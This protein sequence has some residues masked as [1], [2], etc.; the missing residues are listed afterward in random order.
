MVNKKKTNKKA[1]KKFELLIE[2]YTVDLYSENTDSFIRN[3][4]NATLESQKVCCICFRMFLYQIKITKANLGN[5]Q[6]GYVIP[7]FHHRTPT[8]K[9]KTIAFTIAFESK[10]IRPMMSRIWSKKICYAMRF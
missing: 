5:I 2:R 3:I 8:Y 10:N 9:S 4:I 6:A 1:L 7:K